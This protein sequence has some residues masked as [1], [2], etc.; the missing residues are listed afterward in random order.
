MSGIAS[1]WAIWPL[2]LNHN[3]I[4][5][6]KRKFNKNLAE[7][8]GINIAE[9]FNELF[10]LTEKYI[11]NTSNIDKN[12]HLNVK[13]SPRNDIPPEDNSPN[14]NKKTQYTN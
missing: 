14:K 1:L 5:R 10:L 13:L 8:Y 11:N 9:N 6:E 2:I 12:N 3:I 7:Y 4:S